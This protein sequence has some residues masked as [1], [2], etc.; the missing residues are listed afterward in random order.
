MDQCL[1]MPFFFIFSEEWCSAI[2]WPHGLFTSPDN[3]FPFCLVV[4]P[5]IG[6]H[7]YVCACVLVCVSVCIGLCVEIQ[8]QDIPQLP[9][10]PGEINITLSLSLF[11]SLFPQNTLHIPM[12]PTKGQIAS[13]NQMQAF[14]RGVHLKFRF[15]ILSHYVECLKNSGTACWIVL[16][17]PLLLSLSV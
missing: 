3:W 5:W 14:K 6:T 1:M 10:S 4:V 11:P 16:V 7:S 15:S 8:V 9:S 2:S 13:L 12:S 17:A